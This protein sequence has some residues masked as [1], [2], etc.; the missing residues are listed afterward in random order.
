MLKSCQSLNLE[1]D[2]GFNFC[3]LATRQRRNASFR[4]DETAESTCDRRRHSV[5]LLFGWTPLSTL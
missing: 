5:P 1:E 3:G 2:W 4:V